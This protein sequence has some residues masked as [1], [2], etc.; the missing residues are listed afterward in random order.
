MVQFQQKLTARNF[1]WQQRSFLINDCPK[2]RINFSFMYALIS[3]LWASQ[4]RSKACFSENLMI[5]ISELEVQRSVKIEN[6]SAYLSEPFAQGSSNRIGFFIKIV[7]FLLDFLDLSGRELEVTYA[8]GKSKLS[9][10]R[11]HENKLGINRNGFQLE[12]SFSPKM[13][14]IV[15]FLATSKFPYFPTTVQHN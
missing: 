15:C 5:H 6:I 11:W 8:V 12:T 3:I 1:C 13:Q 2:I 14:L 10:I 9:T 4:N 7:I